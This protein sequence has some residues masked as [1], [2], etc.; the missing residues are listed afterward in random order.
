MHVHSKQ[1]T[2]SAEEVTKKEYSTIARDKVLT[3]NKQG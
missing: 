3:K 1:K 2:K